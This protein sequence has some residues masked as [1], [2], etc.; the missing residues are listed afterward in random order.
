MLL[1]QIY[2]LKILSIAKQSRKYYLLFTNLHHYKSDL[3][4]SSKVEISFARCDCGIMETDYDAVGLGTSMPCFSVNL[5]ITK[6]CTC[7]TPAAV[8]TSLQRSCQAES[9]IGSAFSRAGTRPSRY[10]SN[11]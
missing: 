2:Y 5:N 8:V 7:T 4:L 10:A 9:Y 1:H 11:S 3:V 6:T